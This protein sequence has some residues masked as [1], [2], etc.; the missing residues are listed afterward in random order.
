MTRILVLD[1]SLTVRMNLVEALTEAGQQTTPCATV[2]E[3]RELLRDNEF[4]VVI[5]D[6]LLPDGDGV[7]FLA[8]IR[9]D[10][11]TRRLAVLMLSSEEELADRIDGLDADADSYVGKPY[12]IDY[13]VAKAL[14]LAHADALDPTGPAG[15][16]RIL[17]VDDSPTYLFRIAEL[18]RDEGYDVLAAR[19]G[20]EALELL[21][22]QSVDCILL[23]LMMPGM[24][25]QETCR[26]VKDEPTVRDVPLIMLTSMED[27]ETMIDALSAG[28]DDF[29]AKSAEFGVIAARIRA[30]LRRKQ[31]EDENRRIRE[32][33]MR[34]EIEATRARAEARVAQTRAAMVEEL[35]RKNRELEAFSYSVSHDLR[36]P[37]RTVDGFTRVLIESVKAHLDDAGMHY[38]DRI[39]AGVAR[40]TE[41]I[42]DMMELSRVGRAPLQRCQTDLAALARELLADLA[43]RSPERDVDV[44]VAPA[45]PAQADPR[46][47]RHV[48]ENL[49]GNAW[50]FT[51]HN[52][53]A[54]I[55]V[56]TEQL[57][58]MTVYF[59]RDNG[60]GFDLGSADKLFSP[61]QRFH[62]QAEF[63]GTGIGLA[64]VHR[65]IDRH[66]GRVW[67]DSAIDAG[68]TFRFTL[69]S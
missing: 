37:L 50:K 26:R 44:V 28:A 5:L 63:P 34:T 67:A 59:V 18:I 68:A 43:E 48:L 40:M 22:A 60:T 21:A 12:D 24:S 58:G 13:L 66:G 30:Q 38:A 31:F 47:I 49:L 8:E 11:R 3:A 15:P 25:G 17:A 9:A 20:E 62:S 36:A 61:F 29:I 4:D 19:S 14:E 54:R 45:M 65:V 2:A 57:D 27:R 23:D 53:Q 33:L 32:E 46:L 1:D 7:E 35:E 10:P 64:T 69:P 55:E 39:S 51:A 52:P 56:G 6:V 42:D 41:M 16:K